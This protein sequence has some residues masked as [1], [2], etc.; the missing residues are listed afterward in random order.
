MAM[1]TDVWYRAAFIARV[2]RKLGAFHEKSA[3]KSALV[4]ARLIIQLYFLP[5]LINNIS[6]N[7]S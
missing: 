5:T 7:S 2:V 6:Q 1:N 4:I 3:V